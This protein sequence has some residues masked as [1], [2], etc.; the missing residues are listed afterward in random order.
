VIDTL[1]CDWMFTLTVFPPPL[2]ARLDIAS[3][4]VHDAVIVTAAVDALARIGML[5]TCVFVLLA[6]TVMAEGL[7]DKVKPVY[8]PSS[9]V[10]STVAL[11]PPVL[12]NVIVS[13]MVI[14][15]TYGP[16]AAMG[17]KAMLVM[18]TLACDW[19][20]T[21]T[22]V[23]PPLIAEPE[24][25]IVPAQVTAIVAGEAANAPA[26]MLTTNVCVEVLAAETITGAGLF[27]ERPV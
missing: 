21:L 19:M 2:I 18:D 5:N 1:A 26:A 24:Y 8:A 10:A 17:V 6:A 15:P 16:G 13:V 27:H 22:L 7:S 12:L 20:F 9:I 4:P 3:V 25:C 23:G 14:P 11:V